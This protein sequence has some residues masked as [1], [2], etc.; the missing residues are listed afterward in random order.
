M[1]EVEAQ[2][3]ALPVD[4]LIELREGI[5]DLLAADTVD[6][7]ALRRLLDSVAP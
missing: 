4:T 1:S 7:R 2:L 5:E 3:S 6:E